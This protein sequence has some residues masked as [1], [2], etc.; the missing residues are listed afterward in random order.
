MTLSKRR[1]TNC[2]HEL[3]EFGR[4]ETTLG[5]Q[6]AADVHSERLHLRYRL[7]D[8]PGVQPTSQIDGHLHGV[9]DFPAHRPVVRASG[10]AQLLDR[11]GR[12]PGIEKN[13]V[14]K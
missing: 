3:L 12:I 5:A 1:F 9:A 6:S 4:V 7:S 10:A 13:C 2:E 11:E 14:H 8:V